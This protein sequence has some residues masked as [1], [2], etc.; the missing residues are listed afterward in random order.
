MRDRI[1]R[2]SWKVEFAIVVGLAFGWT[3]PGTLRLLAAPAT[4]AHSATPPI[5]EIAVWGTVFLELILLSLLVPFLRVRG[6][7]LARLGIQPSLRGSLQ[8]GALALAAY[9]L[10]FTFALLVGSVWPE[11]ARAL[12]QTRLVGDGVSWTTIV[13]VSVINPFYEEV[14]VCGYVV[15]VFTNKSPDA[16][17]A[18]TRVVAEGEIESSAMEAVNALRSVPVLRADPATAVNI[19]A[20]IRLSYH[21]YQGAA[22]VFA[23]VPL[24]LLFGFWFARTRQLWPLIVAHAILDFAGLSLGAG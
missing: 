8:G 17:V 7:T 11:V 13:F 5:S 14:F 19:S 22:G 2:L 15:S 24:G 20:A 18:P 16:V 4:I 1:R 10:Y 3:L 9:G 12:A 21:L 23:V 6:W